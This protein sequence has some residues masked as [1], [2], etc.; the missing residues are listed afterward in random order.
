MQSS[1]RNILDIKNN[2]N[3]LI[4]VV[5]ELSNDTE[6]AKIANE[7]I[8]Q[9]IINALP[10]LLNGRDEEIKDTNKNLNS[11]IELLANSNDNKNI[12]KILT[13]ISNRI[14]KLQKTNE[15]LNRSNITLIM[16]I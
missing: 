1:Q 14:D 13:E 2:T 7:E 8:Q 9:R 12:L 3:E 15:K 5:D 6:K 11:I 10:S 16:S 4:N